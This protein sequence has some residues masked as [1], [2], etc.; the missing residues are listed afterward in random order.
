MYLV[1]LMA[2]SDA[3]K[4]DYPQVWSKHDHQQ[5]EEFIGM[6]VNK[7]WSQSAYKK[8]YLNLLVNIIEQL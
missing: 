7:G 6:S 4:G 3:A 1:T 5:S 8:C 2:L